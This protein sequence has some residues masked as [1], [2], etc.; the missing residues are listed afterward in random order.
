MEFLFH[1]TYSNSWLDLMYHSFP[2]HIIKNCLY[3]VLG[4]NNFSIQLAGS[5]MSEYLL[6]IKRVSYILYRD[7]RENFI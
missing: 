5:S 1:Y 2:A 6:M 3:H 7:T 4:L